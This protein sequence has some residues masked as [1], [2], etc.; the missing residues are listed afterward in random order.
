VEELRAGNWGLVGQ[1]ESLRRHLGLVKGVLRSPIVIPRVFGDGGEGE[2][3]GFGEGEDG[4]EDSGVDDVFE[5]EGEG[6]GVFEHEVWQADVQ[7]LMQELGL[8]KRKVADD[9]ERFPH[10]VEA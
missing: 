5:V 2:E 7:A 4:G 9:K 1:V 8:F 6:E 3:G 10:P